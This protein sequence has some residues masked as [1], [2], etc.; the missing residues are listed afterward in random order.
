MAREMNM[1]FHLKLSW[2]DLYTKEFSPVKNKDPIRI[3]TGLG[4]ASRQEYRQTFG[5]EYVERT[6]C[7]ELGRI[8]GCW[9]HGPGLPCRSGRLRRRVQGGAKETLTDNRS[10][11]RVTCCKGKFR[12]EKVLPAPPARSFTAFK[13]RKPRSGM[14]KFPALYSQ[15]TVYRIANTFGVKPAAF[16][17]RFT[18]KGPL[19]LVKE[20]IQR[21]RK[22]ARHDLKSGTI[23]SNIFPIAVPQTSDPVAGMAYRYPWHNGQHD[24]VQLSHVGPHAG[25]LS[26][27]AA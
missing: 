24:S 18:W 10:A 7:A 11:T 20:V 16:G 1:Q 22:V 14:T 26:S 21:A 13:R 27:S 5:H 2:D 25:T 8:H 23:A 3:E 9:R 19:A 17:Q 4:V 12:P 15:P 6:C